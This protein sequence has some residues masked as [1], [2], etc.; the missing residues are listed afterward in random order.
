[1]TIFPD[2][3]KF[4]RIKRKGSI[5][6][7]KKREEID[8]G[9]LSG[10]EIIFLKFKSALLRGRTFESLIDKN[11]NEIEEKQI[12]ELRDVISDLVLKE[13]ISE[14]Y[15]P[16]ARRNQVDHIIVKKAVAGLSVAGYDIFYYEDFPTFLPDSKNLKTDTGYS[17]IE[18]DISNVIEEKIQGILLYESLI[19]VYFK[20][21]ELL[22]EKIRETTFEVFWKDIS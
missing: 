8:Y 11:L 16:R 4:Y 6:R 3:R 1:M 15:C 10:V 12:I 19:D 7:R 14:I 2:R 9:K 20:S 17:R 21:K 18:I 13:N 5:Y 22:V